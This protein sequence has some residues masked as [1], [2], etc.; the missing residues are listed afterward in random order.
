MA[1]LKASEL[2]YSTPLVTKV[3]GLLL[4]AT[5]IETPESAEYA[6]EGAL[7]LNL[8]KLGLSNETIAGVQEGAG[9]KASVGE[10]ATTTALPFFAWSTPMAVA[11][12]SNEAAKVVA[13]IFPTYVEQVEGKLALRIFSQETAGI[14]KPMLEP[15]TATKAAVSL[16]QCQVFC[17]GK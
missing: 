3:G 16:C 6:P 13:V 15:K 9:P 17:L 11:K 12:T 1:E 7:Y 10:T 8:A 2:K 5:R 4:T 14:G